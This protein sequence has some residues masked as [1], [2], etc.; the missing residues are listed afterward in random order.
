MWPASS[1]PRPQTE[2]AQNNNNILPHGRLHRDRTT[3]VEP[4]TEK[5]AQTILEITR[6]RLNLA[7]PQAMIQN[8]SE[9]KSV[10][11]RLERKR[12]G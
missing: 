3:L 4:G 5:L 6:P 12:G 1:G 11:Y 8:S 2:V 7:A 10:A 9:S